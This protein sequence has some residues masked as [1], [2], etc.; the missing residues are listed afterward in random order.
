MA[1]NDITLS[2]GLDPKD[3]NQGLREIEQNLSNMEKRVQNLF[4]KLGSNNNNNDVTPQVD[5]T[6]LEAANRQI[7]ELRTQL[8][9][10]YSRQQTGALALQDANA[11]IQELQNNLGG[12]Q[13]ELVNSGLENLS[14]ML[15]APEAEQS[16]QRVGA[17]YRELLEIQEQLSQGANLPD[18]QQRI[19]AIGTEMSSILQT[20][21]DSGQIWTRSEQEIRILSARVT[22]LEAQLRNVGQ[23]SGEMGENVVNMVSA[24]AGGGGAGA[25][26]GA[27]TGGLNKAL[28]KAFRT[29]KRMAGIVLGV[30]LGVR[31]IQAVINKIRG[32]IKEGFHAIYEGDKKFKK[33]VDDLKKS[34]AEV[35]ANLAAAFMPIV[36][37]AIPYIQQLINWINMLIDKIAMFVAAIAGQNS[38]TKAIKATGDAAKGAAKQLSKFDELNNLTT[39]GPSDWSTKQ[40]PV[41]AKMIE[42]AEKFKAILKEIQELFNEL[43]VN[44]FKEGF[45]ST[46]GDWRSKLEEIKKSIK[47]IAKSFQDIFSDPEISASLRKYVQSF[48]RLFGSIAGLIGNYGITTAKLW[49]GGFEKF[50]EDNK[51]NIKQRLADVFSTGTN[52]FDNFTELNQALSQIIDLLSD[53][54]SAVN[55]AANAFGILWE[56]ISGVAL[57]VLKLIEALQLLLLPAITDNVPIIAAAIESIFQI[58]EKCYGFIRMVIADVVDHILDFI[59]RVIVP[60][61]E[62]FGRRLSQ[63]VALILAAWLK[64]QPFILWLTDMIAALW[65]N[66]VSPIMTD[67]IDIIAELVDIMLPVIEESWNRF[68]LPILTYIIQYGIPVMVDGLKNAFSIAFILISEALKNVHNFLEVVKKV[69]AWIGMLLRGDFTKF[70]KE[71]ATALVKLFVDPIIEKLE[72]LKAAFNL[73]KGFFKGIMQGILA[74]GIGCVNVLIAAFEFLHNAIVDFLNTKIQIPDWVPEVG[75]KSFGGLNLAHADWGRLQVPELAT[76]AVIPPSMSSFIAKLGDNNK[77]TEIVSPLSTMKQALLEALQENGGGEYHI[78][79]D[80]D[81]KEIA[82]AVIRQND[83]YKKST[84]KTMFA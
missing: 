68:V 64:I 71:G 6:A 33:Q 55:A 44:P 63:I 81:G 45:N 61:A 72:F 9:E 62:N 18:A 25:I 30:A 50:L 20:L 2:V 15:Y 59:N 12:L 29:L 38:Y 67:I 46:I 47:G 1:D 42:L 66:Y 5:M 84:G 41:D 24:F 4:N 35:K 11:Q 17:L 60:I 75:G 76:G 31:G 19:Q 14:E 27:V 39:N 74:N 54:E 49:I 57:I 52:I 83:M 23:E 77:E 8:N 21:R 51:E 48:F 22:Q 82:K 56:M 53:S 58:A 70:L 13:A 34:W 43:V 80:V 37:M 40:V 32:M 28:N 16:M 10:L 3:I 69:I 7:S 78:H 26:G 65:K 73:F 36:Q 79:V